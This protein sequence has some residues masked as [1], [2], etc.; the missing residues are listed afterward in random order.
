[1]DGF[2]ARLK[3]K[4]PNTEWEII[5]L[6][7]RKKNYCALSPM[8]AFGNRL[9]IWSIFERFFVW[10]TRKKMIIFFGGFFNWKQDWMS[11]HCVAF[12]VI[13][14]FKVQTIPLENIQL[15]NSVLSVQQCIQCLIKYDEKLS[16]SNWK[17]DFFLPPSECCQCFVAIQCANELAKWNHSYFHI[18]HNT[19]MSWG[20]RNGC[21]CGISIHWA[22][23]DHHITSVEWKFLTIYHSNRP[24]RLFSFEIFVSAINTAISNIHVC[25]WKHYTYSFIPTKRIIL[26]ICIWLSY[27]WSRHKIFWTQHLLLFLFLWNNFSNAFQLFVS[28]LDCFRSIV[29]KGYFLS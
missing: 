12:C 29:S 9:L 25:K 24:Q 2:L 16:L 23:S 3:S 26:K 13:V 8:G 10:W 21:G 27:F 15:A 5:N 6:H 18:G 7:A 17:M 1:M 22:L 19:W 4:H 20:V 28:K 14:S 11:V